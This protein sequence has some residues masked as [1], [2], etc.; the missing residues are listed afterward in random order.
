MKRTAKLI[1]V[2]LALLLVTAALAGVLSACNRDGKNADEFVIGTSAGIEHAD[3]S[4]YDFDQ[5]SAGLTQQALVARNTDGT[6]SPLLAEYAVSEDGRD[7]TFTVREGMCWDDGEPVD[8]ADILFTL[9]YADAHDSGG[10]LSSVTDTA[11]ETTP[12]K[13]LSADVSED[14]GSIVFRYREADVRALSDLTVLRIMPEHVYSGKT[15]ETATPAENRVGCG[16]Y[17]FESYSADAG[18]I[19]FVP[20][21]HYPYDGE[22][23][24][25]R[26]VVRLFA[27]DGTL[28]LAMKNGE[29]DTIWKY[30]GGVEPSFA[31]MLAENGRANIIPVASDN[32]PAVLA[33]NTSASPF[34]D[35]DLRKAVVYALDYSR[36]ASLFASEYAETPHAGFVPPSTLGYTPNTETLSR[37]L[38][39]SRTHLEAGLARTGLSS[40]SFTLSVNADNAL[41]LSYA[42]Q[43]KL[44]LE[45]AGISVT[46]KTMNQND[47]RASTTNSGG[48]VSHQACIIGYTANGM[49]MMGGLGTIY[50]DGGHAVQGVS[51]VFDATFDAILDRLS[52]AA[53]EE[54][55][56]SAAKECQEWYAANFPA[57]ALFWDAQLQVLSPEWTGAHADAD[58][59]LINMT[60]WL[61]LGR[62]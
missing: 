33:F 18:T 23:A 59:G 52:A 37:D 13:L 7:Y 50:M 38:T 11:G 25:K 5:L 17:R 15:I 49:K 26:V 46:I 61:T 28:Q 12:S 56:R 42:R 21:E 36:F 24:V 8:A 41:H 55:Y 6:Y 10:W 1:S 30:S 32:L 40:L 9:E 4:D 44:Q 31:S 51:Q 2:C 62:A 43:V 47:F 20:N 58:F 22:L 57:V 3:R 60:T 27:S 19:T 35:A 34:N 39:R 48:N 16:V 53:T 29:L 45:E 14:G 54:D